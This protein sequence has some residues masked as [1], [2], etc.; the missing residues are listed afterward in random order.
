MTECERIIQ[1]GILPESFF[2]EETKCDFFVDKKRKKIW[3][4][5]LDLLMKFDQICRK[6]GLT[7]CLLGGSLLG[8]VRHNGFIP[9]DDD[10]DVGM[11]RKDYD[12]LMQL[13]KEFAEPYFLQTPYTDEGYYYSYNKLRNSNTTGI[14]I[15]FMYERWNQGIPI[16]IFP[17]DNYILEGAAER[18]K[19]IK[20]LILEN[21]NYMRMSNPHL[22]EEDLKRVASHSGRDP[23]EVYEELQRILRQFNDKRT[24]FVGTTCNTVYSHDRMKSFSEDYDGVLPWRFENM[25]VPIPQ[26]YKRILETLFGDYMKLPPQEQRGKGHDKTIFEPDIPYKEYKSDHNLYAELG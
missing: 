20:K 19:E 26:G 21:S 7:Y 12:L 17:L 18:E 23:F 16:D 8:A 6:H 25:S 15:S 24:P 10:I 3:A 13:P 2:E 5:E 11:P 1:Q 22:N 14:S 4:V 9:W